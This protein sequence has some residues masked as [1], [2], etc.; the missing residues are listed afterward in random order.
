VSTIFSS[1]VVLHD[2]GFLVHLVGAAVA[3]EAQTAPRARRRG[4]TQSGRRAR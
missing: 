1:G 3:R 2:P 4:R